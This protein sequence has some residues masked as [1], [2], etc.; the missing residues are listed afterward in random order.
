MHDYRLNQLLNM[1]EFF[2][3]AFRQQRFY[4]FLPLFLTLCLYAHQAAS[5]NGIEGVKIIKVA[6]AWANNSVNAVIFRKNS[7][8]TYKDTQYISF[9]D[10]DRYV[11]LG[12][13]AI[14]STNW[15]LKKTPYQGNTNDSHNTICMMIDGAGYLHLSWDHHNNALRYCKSLMPGSLELTEKIPMTGKNENRVTYPEFYKLENGNLL[16]FYRTGESGQGN[17]VINEYDVQTGKW[18]QLHSNLID[19][20]G[21]R[22]AYWQAYADNKGTIHISWVWRETG[23]VA[24][25]H[26]ICYARSKDGGK[27]WEKSNGEKYN[28]PINAK[29]AEYACRIPQRSELINQTSMT[30]DAAGEPFIA[31]YWRESN[32]TVPQYHLVYHSPEGW[33]TK[34]LTFRSAPFSLSGAGTKRIPISRPQVLVKGK[35]DKASILLVFRDEERGSKA[36]V[37]Q[38]NHLKKGKWSLHN[39]TNYSVGS[40]EP[41]FD[42]ELWKEK[43]IFHLFLQKVE[44]VDGEGRANVP[45]Q[46]VEVLE[47]KPKF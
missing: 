19:G 44:Q 20:E 40:W 33:K 8:V 17:L 3:N 38:M 2:R 27:T 14:N 41:S 39:L 28:L 10:N 24:S 7:L 5:Q 18:T 43:K 47:W 31:T 29:S 13:R 4:Y 37:A 35:G 36:S 45:P 11:V 9:Y 30:A 46:P 6:D 1:P 16:F 12:K 26:D 42:T 15:E 34:E 21:E 23:D 32:S 25:N 22:N